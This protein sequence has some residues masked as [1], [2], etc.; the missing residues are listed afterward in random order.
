MKPK[1]CKPHFAD[2][3]NT[4]VTSVV[5]FVLDNPLL[6]FTNFFNCSLRLP[7]SLILS[8]RR[9]LSWRKRLLICWFLYD[10]VLHHERVNN[11][12]FNLASLSVSFSINR[13]IFVPFRFSTL[14]ICRYQKKLECLYL[15]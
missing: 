1:D 5:S 2:F 13:F 3:K 4:K 11:Q 9:S 14:L 15:L 6:S 8:S 7:I 10:R 12:F